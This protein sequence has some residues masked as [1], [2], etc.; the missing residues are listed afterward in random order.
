MPWQPWAIAAAAAWAQ[1]RR[2]GRRAVSAD[3]AVSPLNTDLRE[4]D[5]KGLF[6]DSN[7]NGLPDVD[8]AF[9]H[10][11]GTHTRVEETMLSNAVHAL[12]RERRSWE[13]VRRG[14][15]KQLRG[16]APAAEV[17]S[18][19][20]TPYSTMN[21]LIKARLYDPKKG[22]TDYIG[23]KVITPNTKELRKVVA[24]IRKGALG[25]KPKAS[26]TKDYIKQPKEDGY[27]AVHFILP[28]GQGPDGEQL[29]V[30]VQVTS[31]RLVM[32]QAITH[33]PYKLDRLNY[34]GSEKL[35]A[36]AYKADSGDP[37]ALQQF[38]WLIRSP[39]ARAMVWLPNGQ[40]ARRARG[41][42]L[43]RHDL[44]DVYEGFD[45]WRR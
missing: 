34:A 8:D 41:R 17:Q 13:K 39:R 35:Y 19:A 31:R 43:R 29:Q 38:D 26:D 15:V 20:K 3:W 22:L 42:R 12:L 10:V 30:E 14:V 24:A 28:I 18:R 45:E 37:E 1:T 44:D 23:T 36:L 25:V 6:Q 4:H 40:A 7:E 9:P 27:R 11:G 16:L 33:E 5:Y 21:K 2:P 32:V